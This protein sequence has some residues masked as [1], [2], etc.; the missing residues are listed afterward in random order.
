MTKLTKADLK[1]LEEHSNAL[2]GVWQ[3]LTA[4][5]DVYNEAKSADKP[6]L[7]TAVEKVLAAYNEAVIQ[8]NAFC[9]GVGETIREYAEGKSE[10]WQESEKGEKYEAW[11]EAWDALIDQLSLKEL[12]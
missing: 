12:A 1:E 5:C 6:R 4:A 2:A 7:K 3:D 8:A 10:K 9:E 11:A